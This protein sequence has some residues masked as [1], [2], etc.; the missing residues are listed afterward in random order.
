MKWIMIALL[1]LFADM[2]MI[3]SQSNSSKSMENIEKPKT[4]FALGLNITYNFIN[5]GSKD[6]SLDTKAPVFLGLSFA[7]KDYGISFS[8]AQP[9][10]Y[11]NTPGKHVPFDADL[12]FYQKHWYEEASVRFYDD[13]FKTSEPF[14]MQFISGSLRGEYI[15][16]ADNFSL[17]SAYALNRIQKHSAGSFILGGNIRHSLIDSSDIGYYNNQQW[18]FSIGPNA[19]YSYTFVFR[20]Y[21]FINLFLLCGTDIGLDFTNTTILFSPYVIPKLVIGKHFKRWSMNFIVGENLLAFVSGKRQDFFN[22]SGVKINF[23]VRF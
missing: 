2:Q 13:F 15:F 3:Y 17:Q 11:D 5:Y 8:I 1:L 22:S 23:V 18:I 6:T 20:N 14:N 4:N 12:V 19:G 21:L 10:T 9:Y 16:N 7:Y